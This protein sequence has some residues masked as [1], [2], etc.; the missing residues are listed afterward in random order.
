MSPC[1]TPLLA[2]ST[3]IV[4]ETRASIKRI[5]VP[6]W[7]VRRGIDSHQVQAE[8]DLADIFSSPIQTSIAPPLIPNSAIVSRKGKASSFQFKAN[9]PTVLPAR[10]GWRFFLL[11]LQPTLRIVSRRKFP[12]PTKG[13]DEGS[14]EKMPQ[15]VRNLNTATREKRRKA[16]KKSVVV[17]SLV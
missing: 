3:G 11:K 9:S 10:L 12:L 1:E 13:F 7:P 16:V 15:I 17:K 5:P 4:H 8:Q 2:L 6:S 14:S